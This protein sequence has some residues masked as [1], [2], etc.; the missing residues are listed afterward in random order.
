M[1]TDKPSPAEFLPGIWKHR[2][3]SQLLELRYSSSGVP[4][5]AALM[6][7][8][9]P[10]IPSDMS[11]YELVEPGASWDS[12]LV[13]IGVGD[14]RDDDAALL[15]LTAA[16]LQGLA[17]S[18]LVAGRIPEELGS[19]A[20]KAARRALTILRSSRSAVT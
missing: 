14:A 5:L 2:D 4:V 1:S 19:S 12:P 18:P 8:A 9:S 17:A 6:H 10:Y 7:G 11:E 3:S 16:A 13:R 20:V 15:R